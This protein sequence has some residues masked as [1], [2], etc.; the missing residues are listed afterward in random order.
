MAQIPTSD[1]RLRL[2]RGRRE[3]H[4][5]A[6][7]TANRKV[8]ILYS[9]SDRLYTAAVT[10]SSHETPDGPL[11]S[12][13]RRVTRAF[14]RR[15]RGKKFPQAVCDESVHLGG[16]V[17]AIPPDA[18]ACRVRCREIEP[19][20]RRAVQDLVE[21]RVRRENQHSR[22]GAIFRESLG[23]CTQGCIPCY[24]ERILARPLS[25]E[26]ICKST[27]QLLRREKG[28][29]HPGHLSMGGTSI[30]KKFRAPAS[31]KRF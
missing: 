28:D 21:E 23:V 1:L 25:C 4:P 9:D 18:P 15:L 16:D 20:F 7:S 13:G 17:D 14:R 10:F 12:R 3:L 6:G 5:R 26:R 24:G 31:Y 22:I 8:Q 30:N 11:P 27:I 29:L 2:P 19:V